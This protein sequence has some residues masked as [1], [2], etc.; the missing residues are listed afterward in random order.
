LGEGTRTEPKGAHIG[1][2]QRGSEEYLENL[3]LD[4][5]RGRISAA[6]NGGKRE[7]TYVV[8]SESAGEVKIEATA[9]KIRK[10]VLVPGART[11]L[12][13]ASSENCLLNTVSILERSGRGSPG[14][15]KAARKVCGT[16]RYLIK[17]KVWAQK[18]GRGVRV[19]MK[20]LQ[21]ERSKGRE[22]VM[23][24]QKTQAFVI[25]WVIAGD[26]AFYYEGHREM[27][28][29]KDRRDAACLRGRG[30][31]GPFEYK[32]RPTPPILSDG[33]LEER[34]K[35]SEKKPR[36]GLRGLV[37]NSSPAKQD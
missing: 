8:E 1:L 29:E 24:N 37:P 18:G 26:Q 15:E 21:M 3:G 19:P 23:F 22:T 35:I 31:K 34:G 17:I 14:N 33:G 12:G 30:R 9:E 16:L 11:K 27:S 10:A 4:G 28:G 2:I 5:K 36:Q 7:T 6:D 20:L 32:P 25:R 13:V